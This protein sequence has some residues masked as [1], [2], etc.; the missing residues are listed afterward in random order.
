MPSVALGNLS[1]EN[2]PELRDRG[3]YI[4]QDTYL[5]QN[6]RFNLI[7]ENA[8]HM[9][10][11]WIYYIDGDMGEIASIDFEMYNAP[12][13]TGY[14]TLTASDSLKSQILTLWIESECK[15]FGTINDGWNL[16]SFGGDHKFLAHLQCEED[17]CH[18]DIIYEDLDIGNDYMPV[19]NTQRTIGCFSWSDSN[20]EYIIHS[21][22]HLENGKIFGIFDDDFGDSFF[23]INTFEGWLTFGSEN[24]YI[25]DPLC[26]DGYITSTEEWEDGNTDDGDG[27]SS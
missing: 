9:F 4:T 13:L 8:L 10:G 1:K 27:C 26:G 12:E 19:E 6:E 18:D 2:D 3:A 25:F 5:K 11:I 20:V 17:L 15:S 23:V 22:R 14:F 21:M 16:I 24:T 7:T